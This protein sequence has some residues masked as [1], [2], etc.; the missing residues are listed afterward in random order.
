SNT[1]RTVLLSQDLS[2]EG[3]YKAMRNM[4]VY[5]TEEADLQIDYRLN[6]NAMGSIINEEIEN[7]NIRA[8]I[9]NPSGTNIKRLSIIVNGGKE[10]GVVEDVGKSTYDYSY[11]CVGGEYTYYYLKVE[12]ENGR[13]AVTAPIWIGEVEKI[14]ISDYSA[15]TFMP[16]KGEEVGLEVTIFNNEKQNLVVDSIE[17]RKG[18]YPIGVIGE[19]IVASGEIKTFKLGYVPTFAGET[20]FEVHVTGH[21]GDNVRKYFTSFKTTVRDGTKLKTIAFDS[22]HQNDYVAGN[23]ANSVS[24]FTELAG[25]NG[26][27]VVMLKEISELTLSKVDALIL[28]PPSRSNS[29][30]DGDGNPTKLQSYSQSEI[31]AIDSWLDKDKT[32]IICGLADYSDAK[33]QPDPKYHAAYQMNSILTKIGAST[34]IRDDEMVD[35]IKNAG[36]SYR[37][38]FKNCNT[39][40]KYLKGADVEKQEYSFY[41]GC[42]IEV[43]DDSKVE[44]LVSTWTST[45]AFDS[46]GDG[47]G[48]VVKG[49]NPVLTV[50]TLAN[51]ATV[52]TAGTVFVSNFEVS[53]EMENA[54][55][56]PYINAVIC[57]NILRHIAPPQFTEISEMKK[58]L[59]GE[60]FT[61]K[62]IVTSNASGHDRATAFFDCIYIQDNSGGLNLFPVSGDYAVG[63]LVMATG[64]VSSY[65]GETQMEV[66]S[67]EIITREFTMPVAKDMTAEESSLK[68]NVGWLARVEGVVSKVTFKEGLLESFMIDGKAFVWI[69]G[70]I[71]TDVDLNW[72]KNGMTVSA[73]G[74]T[75]M[76]ANTQ[77]GERYI[78]RIRV[79]NRNTI[80]FVKG[81]LDTPPLEILS[82]TSDSIVFNMVEGAEYSVDKG[83]T[84]Q[85]SNVFNKLDSDTNYVCVI[86]MKATATQNASAPSELKIVTTNIY[87][88]IGTTGIILIVL[89]S[90]VVVGGGTTLTLLI[91]KKKGILKGNKI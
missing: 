51:G 83:K 73:E 63:D 78:S 29:K 77:S 49:E 15:S 42:S 56:L 34:Q 89:A 21:I 31:D 33:T 25:N 70:Y 1:A 10:I 79:A 2:K 36:Q 41:S 46:D 7:I 37:L 54:T 18:D 59:E 85:D 72:I 26:S 44:T 13:L 76:T 9:V 68:E 69:D 81:A 48:G 17:F 67:S 64:K 39:K 65:N 55:T 60:M 23:Y 82:T 27:R 30:K 40:S 45:Y 57:S 84:W 50:E 22:A 66:T 53:I 19:S 52:F 8:K 35:D 5:A 43:T 88:G 61:V 87:E 71:T 4:R 75:S 90:L 58:G 6:G 14:G 24:N 3:L 38:R 91:L 16:I 86:R 47:K 62:G 80:K 28:T 12:L 32:I 74:L 20:K 11:D